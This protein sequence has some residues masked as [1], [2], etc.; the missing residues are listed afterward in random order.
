MHRQ[1]IQTTLETSISIIE[2]FQNTYVPRYPGITIV[3][4]AKARI[5][6]DQEEFC[7][8]LDAADQNYAR[9][10]Y[11]LAMLTGNTALWHRARTINGNCGPIP[12]YFVF[13]LTE[14]NVTNLGP[15]AFHII[16]QRDEHQWKCWRHETL[17]SKEYASAVFPPF[18]QSQV[19]NQKLHSNK[20]VVP[21]TIVNTKSTTFR[22]ASEAKNNSDSSLYRFQY[23][24]EEISL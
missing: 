15:L 22:V 17:D 16:V 5:F 4:A 19:Y 21:G 11:E 20:T 24:L 7:L 12:K 13:A 18:T 1:K 2:R 10:V 6:D 23:P 9:Q 3:Q 8:S 14:Q